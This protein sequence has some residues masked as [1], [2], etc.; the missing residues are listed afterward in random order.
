MLECFLYLRKESFILSLKSQSSNTSKS[1]KTKIKTFHDYSKVYNPLK[2]KQ[3]LKLKIK[4]LKAKLESFYTN[5]KSFARDI[6]SKPTNYIMHVTVIALSFFVSIST[7]Y[8]NSAVYSDIVPNQEKVSNKIV[9]TK[10]NPKTLEGIAVITN[11][12]VEIKTEALGEELP[13]LN[14]SLAFADNNSIEGSVS[15]FDS[16]NKR[17]KII[18]YTVVDGDTV[19]SI[20]K[21]FNITTNTIKWA[22]NLGDIDSVKPGQIIQILPIS[23]TLHKVAEGEDLNK[24][25]STY[26]ASVPQILDENGLVD[27]NVEV[28]Q[29]LLIPGGRKWEPPEPQPESKPQSSRT[30]ASNRNNRNSKRGTVSYISGKRVAIGRGGNKFAYGY[31]TYYVAS[32]RSIH[33]RGNAGAWLRNAR[34]AGYATGYTPQAGAIIVTNES[35][36]GHVGIVES[37]NSGSIT[38]S[39]M[40][41]A[42][43]GV[44]SR[45]TISSGSGVIRGYIY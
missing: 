11:S 32:R 35:P 28:G 4:V 25:A 18:N 7:V 14:S 42:G 24:I 33:W 22:N 39:E 9:N 40:N 16:E 19:W 6:L 26:S 31:C 23:G 3:N 45:R 1:T 17:E 15:L 29:I 37:V 8:G 12:P 20:A 36:V 34:A 2:R 41:Y 13:S 10:V 21:K 44:V 30:Y 43:W 27:E 38:I 5:S